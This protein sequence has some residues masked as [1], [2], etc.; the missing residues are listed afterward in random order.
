MS[1]MFLQ[2]FRG[3]ATIQSLSEQ[4]FSQEQSLGIVGSSNPYLCMPMLRCR[5]DGHYSKGDEKPG[6]CSSLQYFVSCDSV[7]S[8]PTFNFVLNGVEFPLSPS[9]YILQ[10]RPSSCGQSHLGLQWVKKS[11]A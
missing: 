5:G 6:L 11:Y 8:L 9:F 7:S 3:R 1:Y 4:K 10:V 2:I